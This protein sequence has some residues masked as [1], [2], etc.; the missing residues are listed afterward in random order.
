MYS[1]F[2]QGERKDAEMGTL[3]ESEFVDS[4]F[5]I[6]LRALEVLGSQ[7]A[8]FET[9]RNVMDVKIDPPVAPKHRETTLKYILREFG[10]TGQRLIDD[11]PHFVYSCQYCAHKAITSS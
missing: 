10:S 5:K 7:P 11:S 6:V 8:I 3:N 9:S 1:A 4:P 2:L